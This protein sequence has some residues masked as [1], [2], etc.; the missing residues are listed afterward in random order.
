[1][2]K[3]TVLT[4]THNRAHLLPETIRSVLAQ[5]FTDF[6]YVI[7][8]DGSTD[9]TSRVVRSFAEEDGRIRFIACPH[10][11]LA[12]AWEALFGMTQGE[13]VAWLSDDD[14]WEPTFLESAVRVLDESPDAAVAYTDYNRLVDGKLVPDVEPRR[15]N[16]D[17]GN[18]SYGCFISMCLALIRRA[19]LEKV[20]DHKGF[21]F[22]PIGG[23]ACGDWVLFLNLFAYGRFVHICEPLGALRMHAEQDSVT[24]SVIELARRRF[25][26]RRKYTGIAWNAA[27]RE[28]FEII[29]WGTF[30]RLR[31]R[32]RGGQ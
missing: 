27:M 6:E 11:G 23:S 1:M 12:R 14:L 24:T 31:K 10:M 3:V 19:T 30:N 18:L 9:S 7:L 28:A 17:I 25:S 26:V 8:S 13:Y 22:D 32:L 15:C 21:Y 20:R 16:L 5:T 29:A 2:A 4:A